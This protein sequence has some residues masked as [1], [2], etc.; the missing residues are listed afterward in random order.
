ML[1]KY[2]V[3]HQH[4]LN[5]IYIYWFCHKKKR[6]GGGSM[7]DSLIYITIGNQFFLLLTCPT[8]AVLDTNLFD[9]NKIIVQKDCQNR[10]R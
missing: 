2:E 7:N 4:V 6:T 1:E 3:F 10:L 9:R 8:P 5:L